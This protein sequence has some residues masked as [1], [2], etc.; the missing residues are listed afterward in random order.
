MTD[1]HFRS[2]K[3]TVSS[4]RAAGSENAR[5]NTVG[6]VKAYLTAVLIVTVLLSVWAGLC[7]A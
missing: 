7:S 4:S 3:E 1:M 6:G 2:V 5:S